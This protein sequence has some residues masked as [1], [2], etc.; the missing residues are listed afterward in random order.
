MIPTGIQFV[1]WFLNF[2]CLRR[3]LLFFCECTKKRLEAK[4]EKTKLWGEWRGGEGQARD[5]QKKLLNL[6]LYFFPVGF[7]TIHNNK[8]P[9][10]TASVFYMHSDHSEFAGVGFLSNLGE[11]TARV[12]P[13]LGE[14]LT[15]PK[16]ISIFFLISLCWKQ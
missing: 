5:S 13:L 6:F 3:N 1:D 9:H 15:T 2:R 7:F 8:K 12:L 10:V 16:H 4:K 11:A 14:E